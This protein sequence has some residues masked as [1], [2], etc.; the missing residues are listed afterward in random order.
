MQ[1]DATALN[2]FATLAVPIVFSWLST[3]VYEYSNQFNNPD[4][5]YEQNGIENL[6]KYVNFIHYLFVVI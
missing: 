1:M 5:L 2:E 3:P 6:V 4:R